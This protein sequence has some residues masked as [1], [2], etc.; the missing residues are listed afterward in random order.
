[1]SQKVVRDNE[2]KTQQKVKQKRLHWN[3]REGEEG[4]RGNRGLNNK[5]IP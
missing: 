2:K 5:R 1:M 4:G 3:L